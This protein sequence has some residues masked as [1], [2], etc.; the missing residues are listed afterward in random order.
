MVPQMAKN[1][2]EAGVS[3]GEG[4]MEYTKLLIVKKEIH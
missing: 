2:A 1:H 4:V 3:I